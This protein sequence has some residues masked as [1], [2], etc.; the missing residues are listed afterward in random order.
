MVSFFDS[1]L[2]PPPPPG[3]AFKAPGRLLVT[4]VDAVAERSPTRRFGLIPNGTEVE[5]GFREVTFQDLSRAVDAMAWWIVEALGM[6]TTKEE[7]IAYLG[8]NDVRYIVFI[9]ACHKLGYTTACTHLLFSQEKSQIASRIKALSGKMRT[10]E[11]PSVTDTFGHR[12]GTKRF[13][14]ARTY[15]EMVNKIAFMIHSSGTT[16]MPKP[17]PLTHGFL[18]TM[19][20]GPSMPRPAGRSSSFF[21]DLAS[22]DPS[23]TDLVLSSTPYFHLM[24]LVSFFE[25]IFH[26]IPFVASPEKLLSVGFLIDLIRHTKP[27]ATILPPSILEDMSHS[28]EGLACLG[29]MKFVCYGG[30]P[31]APE[32]G[33]RLSRYTELRSPIGSSE[34]GI[35]S[36]MVPEGEGNWGYFEWTP[37]YHVDMQ[38]IGDGLYELVLPR[39]EHSLVIHGIFHTFP[40]LKEYRSKDLYTRHPSN[41]RLWRYHGR[42]DDVIVLSNGEKLSPVSLEK[43]VEGHPSVHR[44]LLVGQ[45]RFQTCLLIEPVIDDPTSDATDERTEEEFVESI[46]PV[47]QAANETVPQYG[48]VVK[49]MIRL[50]SREK[51]FKLTAKG[52]TQRH[53]VNQDYAGE[54][55]EI[56]AAQD[57]RMSVA[58]PSALTREG[59]SAYLQGIIST[60]TGKSDIRPS[61]DLYG[62]GLDSLQAIQ[63]SKTLKSSVSAYSSQCPVERLQVQN[64][65]AHPTVDA[66]TDLL[67]GVLDQSAVQTAP[68]TRAERI[69]QLISKYTGDLHAPPAGA[70]VAPPPARSTVILT[71]STGSLGTYILEELLRNPRV[72]KVYCFNRSADAASR[73]R[74]GFEE[75]GLSTWLLD[76]P[77]QVEFWQVEFGA[78]Q[79]GLP[80]ERYGE[81]LGR[82]DLIIHNA[83]KVNFNHPVSS[84]EDPHLRG[85]RGFVDLS[86]RSRHRAHLAFVSSVS[87]IGAWQPTDAGVTAVPEEPM[88]SVATALAQGYGESKFV[89]ERICVEAWA[90]AGVASSILRVG[91]IAGPDSPRGVWN[92]HEWIP[93]LVKSSKASGKVPSDLGG[94]PVDWVSVDSLARIITEL[95]LNPRCNRS[96]YPAVFH[97][98]NPSRTSWASLVPAIQAR[99]PV[100]PVPLTEWLADLQA[101]PD[102][103]DQ[104]VEAKPALKL[105]GFFRALADNDA[106]VLSADISVDRAKEGSP[107]MAAL[108]PVSCAQMSNWLAQWDF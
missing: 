5:N 48:Q 92:P 50:S 73:Q 44:A 107:T 54:I 104:E 59:V 106:A 52:T 38:P 18:G 105:L 93:A 69:A 68:V 26:N 37:A 2:H 101:I 70:Q 31:L 79:F 63:L 91:Q 62:L 67:L 98:V 16:G 99:Y 47:V 28:E 27:T 39:V 78:R 7:T 3:G 42:L 102:P 88:A 9:L 41:P 83:W 53:A 86:T 40:Q 14:F 49:T 61:D 45:R 33:D 76:D 46:W 22:D 19:D 25:S 85:V 30:A 82:V 71:G 95:L 108:G 20:Y 35:I 29:S 97:L 51:P 43:I 10:H 55:E 100:Q 23:P 21:N 72:A 96:T 17:V 103:S 74:A 34:M 4:Q 90:R 32:V 80:D 6:P 65:Y 8:N 57:R 75:K 66:L 87:T 60:L 84:F 89:G 94:Y 77:G 1:P 56:Y 24:G 11:V 12:S 81:L 13:D 58:L 36:S 15:D 64:I